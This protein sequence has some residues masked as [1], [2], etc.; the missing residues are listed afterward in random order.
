MMKRLRSFLASPIAKAFQ[1]SMSA[2]LVARFAQLAM[3]VLAARLLQPAGFGIFTFAMGVGLLG[4]RVGSLGWPTLMSRFVPLYTINRDWSALRGLLS[5]ATAVMTV[6]S[7]AFGALCILVAQ[8]LG[9]ESNLYW[10]MLLGGL[11]LPAMT[12]RSL[13]RNL[14][15]ALKVPQ[16]GIMVDEL[17]PPLIMTLLLALPFFLPHLIQ[18][19]PTTTVLAYGAASVVAV[20]FGYIWIRAALPGESTGRQPIYELRYW[21]MTALPAMVGMS[22]KLFMNKSDVLML[23][24]LSTLT[25]V[26]NYGVALRV[27]YIQTAPIIVLSTVITSKIGTAIAMRDYVGAKRLFKGALA[28]AA[29]FSIPL[30]IVLVVFAEPILTLLFG[31]AY[32]PAAPALIYLAIGQVGAALN[33]PTA[34]FMLMSGRQTLFG[35]MTTLGLV[36]NLIGN[37]FLIPPLGAGGSALATAISVLL[38]TLAQAVACISIIRSGRYEERPSRRQNTGNSDE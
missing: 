9:P 1:R 15:A 4:G 26:G 32:A 2:S 3:S 18:V 8:W 29:A 12:F 5:A 21:M 17:I 34:S 20:V 36:A 14:L 28:F 16:R 10:G 19:N 22:A 23:A 38:L 37:W 31:S 13:Y 11:I 33:V 6:A 7:I 35:L 30:A 27:T 25:E 24:P